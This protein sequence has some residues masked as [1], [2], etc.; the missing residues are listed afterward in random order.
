MHD[1]EIRNELGF[2]VSQY[3]ACKNRLYKRSVEQFA[4]QNVSDLAYH[5]EVSTT[6][7][8]AACVLQ[9]VGSSFQYHLSSII[10]IW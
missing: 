5:K 8:P 4:K 1:V 10:G 6:C 9:K 7:L 2:K 3:Y